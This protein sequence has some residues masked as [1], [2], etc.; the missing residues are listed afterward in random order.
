MG[1]D[2]PR[3][4]AQLR[5]TQAERS[6]LVFAKCYFP[7]HVPLPLSAAHQQLYSLLAEISTQRGKK[8]AVAAPRDFGK[9]TTITTIYV[10][11]S[12]CFQREQFIVLLGDTASQATQ[13]LENV[14][15]ELVHNRRLRT[16]FPELAEWKG[17]PKPPRWTQT[18]IE[19]RTGIK[20][21]ARGSHQPIRGRKHGHVRPTLVVADDI[22]TADNTFSAESRDKLNSW[23]NRA[24]LKVGSQGT[25]YLFLGTLHHPHCLLAEYL[26]RD[27]HPEW[28]KHCYQAVERWSQHLELWEQWACIL[29]GKE[30]YEGAVGPQAAKRFYDAHEGPMLEGT[31]MLWPEKWSYY[32]L[33]E[34]REEDETSFYS[35]YQNEPHNPA[36]CT[37]GNIDEFSY[38]DSPYR[39]VEE[40]QH[41]LGKYLEYMGACD[42]S[43]GQDTVRGDYSAIIVLA[44]DIR[45]NT[46]YLVVADIERRTP[47]QTIE[48]ILAYHQ[49]FRCTRF[50]V[51][52]NQ[53]QVLLAQE[54]DRRAR[55]RGLHLP[56][57]EVKNTTDKVKR[58]QSLHPCIKN[59]AL[60]FSKAHRLL[61]EECRLFPKGKHDDGLDA[62][63]MAVRLT[64]TGGEPRIR[65]I[66]IDPVSPDDNDHAHWVPLE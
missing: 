13:T 35:E 18:E 24:L 14:K 32:R 48:D 8:V 63:E 7:H 16:D 57:E 54:L 12:M 26:Q 44:R 9:S 22:E 3:R 29:H 5:R 27:A 62:L 49:R 66:K 23:F 1:D 19:T 34:I 4:L 20:V 37:F 30:P 25:N 55:A 31:Q 17:Q 61:L 53:F 59:G 36:E 56:I 38:W 33:M 47:T 45:D 64:E 10:L 42:P 58:I 11:Y 2:L 15:R 40:L 50:A 21:L 39:S 51:E 65:I 46:L 28:I 43:L 6:L 60:K 41:T 52:V